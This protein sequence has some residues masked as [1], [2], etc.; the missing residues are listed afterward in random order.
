MLYLLITGDGDLGSVVPI[1]SVFAFTAIRLFPRA[2]AGLRLARP[3]ALR[4]AGTLDK[5]HKDFVATGR[6]ARRSRLGAAPQGPAVRLTERLELATCTTPIRKPSG[7]RSAG[8]DLAIAARTTVGI[9]G[10]TGAGKTTAV[11]IML[12][13]LQPQDGALVVDGSADHRRRRCAP[14]SARSAT[15]RST[16]S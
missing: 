15:C 16:S 10:G 11:D 8:S 6:A 13:L 2:A 14:G 4:P 3:D 12:G 5:L 1:L 9:V 7:R